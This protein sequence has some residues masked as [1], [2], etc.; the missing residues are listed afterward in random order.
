VLDIDI[1]GSGRERRM[2]G[3]G[4]AELVYELYQDAAHAVRWGGGSGSGAARAAAVDSSRSQKLTIYGVVPR[5]TDIPPGLYT[6]QIQVT[7][8]F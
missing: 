6:D 8:R 4:G 3:P 1:V 2:K 7:L 5:Q